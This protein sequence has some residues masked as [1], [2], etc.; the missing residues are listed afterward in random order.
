MASAAPPSWR[1]DL[2]AALPW[3]DAAGA[4]WIGNLNATHPWRVIVG[5]IRL[6]DG[7]RVVLKS[8]SDK[9]RFTGEWA[10]AR[11]LAGPDAPCV[12]PVCLG[13]D[14]PRRVLVFEHVAGQDLVT[15]LDAEGAAAAWIEAVR[16]VASFHR[17]ADGFMS[18]WEPLRPPGTAS[19][20][21]PVYDLPQ[22]ELVAPFV[23]VGGKRAEVTAAVEAARRAYL[24]PGRWLGFTHGDLQ[25]RHMLHTEAG[26]RIIDW[27][28]AGPRH[29]LYDLACLIAKPINHGRRLPRWAQEVAIEEYARVS[30]FALEAVRRELSQVLAY[31]YLI[32]VAEL[33]RGELGPAEARACLEG[34]IGLAESDSRLAPLADAAPAVLDR[35]PREE[36]PLFAG[37]QGERAA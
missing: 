32:G 3:T 26:L 21:L 23:R 12:A 1:E 11:F 17:W 20:L 24:E 27:E 15:V 16:V 7:R 6:A 28:H 8:Q 9:E 35:L 18:R 10:A 5:D 22:V 37:L 29:R 34:L 13:A 19:S 14:A 31:E 36:L 4:E 30:A 33:D 2:Q 25:T